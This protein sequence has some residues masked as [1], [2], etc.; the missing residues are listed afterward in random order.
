MDLGE[1]KAKYANLLSMALRSCLV[2]CRDLAGNEHAVEVTAESLYEAVA[3]AL[4]IL[5][6]DQWVEE[7]GEALLGWSCRRPLLQFPSLIAS[8]GGHQ[9]PRRTRR[10][11]P[12]R[13]PAPVSLEPRCRYAT[14]QSHQRNQ[15]RT[16]NEHPQQA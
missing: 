7:I 13:A 11:A 9:L 2:S 10:V 1:Q 4:G 15:V 12:G 5:R 3:Q 14:R 8:Q 6:G 16:R